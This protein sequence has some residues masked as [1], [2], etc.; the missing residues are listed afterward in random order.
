MSKLE[1][2][3]NDG[4]RIPWLGFGTGTAL[5]QQDASDLVRQAIENGVTH[6][7][8]AQMYQNEETLGQGIKLSG[9][10]RSELFVTTKLKGLSPGQTVKDTLLDSLKK[11]GLD[12]VDLFLV[13]DP[14]PYTKENRLRDVWSQ[15][16]ALKDEGLAKSVGVSNFKVEDLNE[17]LPE[18]KIIP[19]MNQVGRRTH[20]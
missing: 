18:A 7:D 6:L 1:F 5:Y 14:T 3:L 9:K 12:Y 10:P 19:S 20:P 15:M 11:L 16:E 8:G 17:I 4:T 13:H 2:T